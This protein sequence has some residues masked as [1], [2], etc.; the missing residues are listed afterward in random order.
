[1][2][3]SDQIWDEWEDSVEGFL[4]WIKYVCEIDVNTQ[5]YKILF[6]NV[7]TMEDLTLWIKD[8][9]TGDL[10]DIPESTYKFLKMKNQ[11]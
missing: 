8:F 1:M 9:F 3:D 6:E 11:I 7:K 10:D 2:N 5:V 4:K